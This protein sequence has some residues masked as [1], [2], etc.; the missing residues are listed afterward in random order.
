MPGTKKFN[1]TGVPLCVEFGCWWLVGPWVGWGVRGLIQFGTDRAAG[2][3]F[4]LSLNKFLQTSDFL[5]KSYSSGLSLRRCWLLECFKKHSSKEPDSRFTANRVFSLGAK[6]R[7]RDGDH[8]PTQNPF[9]FLNLK[10][11][12]YSSVSV[13][14]F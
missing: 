3:L 7:M 13:G 4:Y 14:H 6:H 8:L 2:V 1:T 11:P 9:A 12:L 5:V 10:P